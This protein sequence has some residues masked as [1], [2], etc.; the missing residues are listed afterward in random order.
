MQDSLMGQLYGDTKGMNYEVKDT[1]HF[2]L[3]SGLLKATLEHL[4]FI[5]TR[6]N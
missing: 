1:L 5:Q 2:K 6:S 3:K 4:N